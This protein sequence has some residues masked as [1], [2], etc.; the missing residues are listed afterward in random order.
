MALLAVV[1]LIC[2]AAIEAHAEPVQ[3]SGNGHWYEGVVAPAGN[4]TWTD[5]R[6]AAV[7]RGGYLA[8]LTSAEEDQFVYGLVSANSDLWYLVETGWKHGPWLGG[9]AE[10]SAPETYSWYWVTGEPWSYSNWDAYQPD[11]N[12]SWLGGEWYLHFAN[13]DHWND[14]LNDLT[15]LSQ[16][17]RGYVVEY[18]IPE[19]VTPSLLAL[20][21]LGML[22]R[23]RAST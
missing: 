19:P 2:G 23:R 18:D 17:I 13:G 20:G 11:H 22:R 14:C 5:A 7:A 16:M 12:Y 3:W 15:V 6:D 9:Y 21:A 1:G 10:E 4:I 8:T